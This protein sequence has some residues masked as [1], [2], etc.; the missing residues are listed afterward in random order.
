MRHPVTCAS[1]AA[2]TRRRKV[3][4]WVM[5]SE[6]TASMIGTIQTDSRII[7]PS[8]ESWHH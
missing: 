8:D 1:S 7:T 2:A 5:A 4:V 3:N 6:W